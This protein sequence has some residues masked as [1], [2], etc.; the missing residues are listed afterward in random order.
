MKKLISF[1]LALLLVTLPLSPYTLAEPVNKVNLSR[2][3]DS[4]IAGTGYTYTAE[5]HTLTVIA[6]GLSFYGTGE[7]VFIK[8]NENVKDI[9]L[10][11]ATLSGEGCGIGYYGESDTLT[12]NIDG[13]NSIQAPSISSENALIT[14]KT[15]LFLKGIGTLTLSGVNSLFVEKGNLTIQD[16]KLIASDQVLNGLWVKDGDLMIT[17]AQIKVV[18][19]Y[20]SLFAGS[21]DSTT[22]NACGG[23]ITITDST[24]EAESCQYASIVAFSESNGEE[25]NIFISGKA[26]VKAN[27]G[28]GDSGSE[29]IYAEGM[30]TLSL[31]DDGKLIANGGTGTTGYHDSYACGINAKSISF[32]FTSLAS[33]KNGK[34]ITKTTGDTTFQLIAQDDGTIAQ[35]LTAEPTIAN[36]T[37]DEDPAETVLPA[38]QVDW[39]LYTVMG[40]GGLLLFFVLLRIFL[41]NKE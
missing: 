12:I 18:S 28:I 37:E 22:S 7:N 23:N 9:T 41:K 21:F 15:S 11:N 14:S 4:D 20:A 25:G 32:A 8:I 13:I 17:D 2:M 33:P 6:S 29:G 19:K 38:D 10:S 31:S 30:L 3:T 27:G 39:V 5:T 24:I 26:R 36:E 34:I 40:V 35:S 1:V 16:I